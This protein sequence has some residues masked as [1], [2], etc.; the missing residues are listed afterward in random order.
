MI[1]LL[2]ILLVLI[3]IIFGYLC[4][5]VWYSLDQS[6]DYRKRW[7]GPAI[8]VVGLLCVWMNAWNIDY[9]W[10]HKKYDVDKYDIVI[11]KIVE[12]H[13]DQIDTTTVFRII[14]K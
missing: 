11:E 2:F 13:N 4:A 7:L 6:D 14:E 3:S 9:S 1:I 12:D 5:D 10:Q 8:L